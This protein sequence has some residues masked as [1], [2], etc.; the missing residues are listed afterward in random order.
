M[1]KFIVLV[2]FLVQVTCIIYSRFVDERFFCWA[3]FDQISI[4]E[5]QVKVNSQLLSSQAIRERYNLPS[6]GRE[7]RSIHNVFDIIRQYEE[8]YGKGESASILV[9]YYTNGKAKEEW[10]FKPE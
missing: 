9:T 6:I 1:R 10:G 7:N 2:F 3:P 4:Y 5:I 8:S